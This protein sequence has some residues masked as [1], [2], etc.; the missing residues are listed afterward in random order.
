[1]CEGRR[2]GYNTQAVGGTG[3]IPEG[4]GR[5]ESLACGG[6]HGSFKWKKRSKTYPLEMMPRL[7][8][9]ESEIEKVDKGNSYRL[10]GMVVW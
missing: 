7:T 3:S 6:D 10:S 1:M 2:K 4:D 5:G 8:V 9:W